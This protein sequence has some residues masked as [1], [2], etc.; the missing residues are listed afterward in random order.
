MCKAQ[1]SFTLKKVTE[2]IYSHEISPVF[3]DNKTME[4]RYSSV[5]IKMKEEKIDTL[6]IYADKE[7]GQNFEY[8]TGFIPR[9]E[10]ALL[11]LQMNGQNYLL[12]GNENLKMASFSRIKAEAVHVPYFSL[13]NQPMENELSLREI[14]K[15]TGVSSKSKIGLIGWKYFTSRFEDNDQLFDIP[16]YI[17]SAIQDLVLKKEQVRNVSHLFISAEG[18]VRTKNNANEIAHYEFGACLASRNM[19]KA[20]DAIEAGKSE[21]EVG[22]YL[23]AYG[24]SNNVVMISATGDRFKNANLYPTDKKIMLGDKV[25]LTTGFSGGLSSRSGYAVESRNDL[26]KENSDYLEKVVIPYLKAYRTWLE[27]IHIGMTGGALYDLI[28]EI[29]PKE[30]YGWHLNPGH[31]VANEE[32]MSSP[33]Y[34]NS[35]IQLRSGM[36]FQID[37]IPSVRGYAGISAEEGVALADASLQTSIQASYPLLWERFTERRKYIQEI[38]NIQ[39]SEE[40][41]PMS[42]IVGYCRPYLLDKERAMV[43]D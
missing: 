34:Q 33:F 3:L 6:I 29:L 37:I 30:K 14:F 18:G 42:D 24:Q 32:W 26:L 20:M 17:V 10:E 38:L 11:V 12:L 25:S 16:F 22:Q 35:T 28:E 5:M 40:I 19:L 27:E 43:S 1:R 39:I 36:L 13:P 23:S 8:L 9:F 41:L 15:K 4:K 31:L 7:H 2:P 21:M